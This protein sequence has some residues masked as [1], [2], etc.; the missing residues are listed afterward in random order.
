[1]VLFSSIAAGKGL[2]NHSVIASAKGAV[3]AFGK[4]LAAEW[5]PKTRVNVIA[6]SL[7]NSKIASPFLS[8]SSLKEKISKGHPM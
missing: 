7:T 3:E 4:S 8:N 1:V 5:A 6:P 2:P